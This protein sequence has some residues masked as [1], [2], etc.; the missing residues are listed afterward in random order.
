MET[1]L[2][3]H[4]GKAASPVTWIW[5]MQAEGQGLSM[6]PSHYGQC[7]PSTVQTAG[8]SP[9]SHHMLCR[10]EGKQAVFCTKAANY[11][12]CKVCAQQKAK[13]SE[14]WHVPSCSLWDL[15]Q[16]EMG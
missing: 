10:Q 3:T 8:A 7:K 9:E 14:D 16:K 4:A 15:G 1:L 13:A 11:R 2:G 6:S 12:S 5:R